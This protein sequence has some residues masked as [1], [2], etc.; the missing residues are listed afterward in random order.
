MSVLLSFLAT[1]LLQE[2]KPI[3]LFDGKSLA[4][5]HFDVPDL[6]SN[7]DG[8]KPFIA[9]DGMLVSVG[10]PIGHLITDKSFENYRLTV[11]YRYSKGAGNCGVIV[12]VSKPRV[13]SFL[14]QGIEAQLMS[15]KAGDFHMFAEKLFKPGSTTESAGKNSTDDSEKPVGEWNEMVVECMADTIKVWVNGTLVN[16]G[17]GCTATKGQIALQSE[18]AEVEFRKLEVLQVSS[19]G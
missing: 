4:G 18:G 15:G 2:P 11:Q 10:K 12:H 14:P 7:P 17:V 19:G 8:T 13:R 16:H 5:W 3:S 6:D 1:A 9:R